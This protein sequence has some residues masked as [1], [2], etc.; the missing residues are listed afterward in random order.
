MR[1]RKVAGI[2]W[3]ALFIVAVLGS[4]FA[5]S[6]VQDCNDLRVRS[7]DVTYWLAKRMCEQRGNPVSGS[8]FSDPRENQSA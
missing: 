2:W 7:F 8:I 3:V 1:K 4:S 5:K 6:R